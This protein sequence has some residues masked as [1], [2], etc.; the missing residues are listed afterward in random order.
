MALLACEYRAV[1]WLLWLWLLLSYN[2]H[3]LISSKI[4]RLGVSRVARDVNVTYKYIW[5]DFQGIRIFLLFED[6]NLY[7]LFGRVL[8]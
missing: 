7:V 8:G 1:L 3:P 4:G 2:K 5:A 6:V